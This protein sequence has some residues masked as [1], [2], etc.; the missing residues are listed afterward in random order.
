VSTIRTAAD[1]IR[2][3]VGALPEYA[4]SEWVCDLGIVRAPRGTPVAQALALRDSADRH[5]IGALIATVASPDVAA[6]LADLLDA[7][8][9][10][11]Q[12]ITSGDDMDV[13]LAVYRVH[14]TGDSLADTITR[15]GR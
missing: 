14:A 13:A 1:T 11:R 4:R 2:A 9:W 6:A 5:A 12:A 10:W 7:L 3:L 15:R 8:A